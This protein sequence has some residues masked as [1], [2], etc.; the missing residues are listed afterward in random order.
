MD[1]GGPGFDLSSPFCKASA[2][3]ANSY[4]KVGDILASEWDAFYEHFGFE[5]A[6]T[7]SGT[8]WKLLEG[9]MLQTNQ[10]IIN[11]RSFSLLLQTMTP[12]GPVCVTVN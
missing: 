3:Q 10:A 6:R 9:K 8:F 4:E 2:G 12:F 5:H 1:Q 11:R 7:N